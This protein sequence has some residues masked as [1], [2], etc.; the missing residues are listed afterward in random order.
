[1]TPIK[2]L[3]IY[4]ALLDFSPNIQISYLTKQELIRNLNFPLKDTPSPEKENEIAKLHEKTLFWMPDKAICLITIVPNDITFN[5]YES[6]LEALNSID[7]IKVEEFKWFNKKFA[8]VTAGL[9]QYAKNQLIYSYDFG[10]DIDIKMFV[11][12]ND[13]IN[14]PKKNRPNYNI[15]SFCEGCNLCALSCPAKAIH[16]EEEGPHWLDIRACRNFYVYGDHPNIISAKHGIN[17]FLNNK[18]SQEELATV[19][20]DKSFEKLFGFKDKETMVDMDGSTY[21]LSIDFCRECMNQKPC[22]KKEH[23]YHKNVS[24]QKINF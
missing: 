22:R 10:F 16:I 8:A 1:M 20:D 7:S 9:G 4:N 23:I 21:Q 5:I 17:I 19:V 11:V 2:F 3:N 14:L 6:A 15:L 12:Y 13:V 18:Y 24:G